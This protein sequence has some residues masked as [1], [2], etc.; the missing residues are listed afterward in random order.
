[1]RILPNIL[2]VARLL[3]VP[4]FIVVYFLF[5]A[6][7]L[8][9]FLTYALAMLTDAIDGKLARAMNC[10]TRFGALIDPLADKF[11][12]LAAVVCLT[13]TGTLSIVVLVLV[14]IRE[15]GMIIGGAL[16][17]RTGIVIFAGIPGKIST[18]LFTLA[19]ALI[20][21][22]H[23]NPALSQVGTILIYPAIVLSF[24]AAI[25]YALILVK[26]TATVKPH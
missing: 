1:M 24:Y 18:L 4:V 20:I 6:Q 14:A 22:W 9:A 26:K 25:H 23:K 3:M 17:A 5:P 13:Y 10:V 15:I 16:A 21:P 8:W 2:T 12:T 19:I 11:M 7:P